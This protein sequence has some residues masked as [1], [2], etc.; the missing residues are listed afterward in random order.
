[1]SPLHPEA[2]RWE[3]S[4]VLHETE[5]AGL[6]RTPPAPDDDARAG[7]AADNR[8]GLIVDDAALGE[9]LDLTNPGPWTVSA[10][11]LDDGGEPWLPKHHAVLEVARHW[12]GPVEVLGA[13]GADGRVRIPADRS[14]RLRVAAVLP[15]PARLRG[16]VEQQ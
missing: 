7:D 9:L 15:V 16:G 1:M 8:T 4:G 2:R 12:F 5:N 3:T 14:I 11:V 6:Y 10:L 13:V